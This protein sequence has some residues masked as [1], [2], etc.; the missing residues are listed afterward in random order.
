[1]KPCTRCKK[2]HN[3]KGCYCSVCKAAMDK[4]WRLANPKAQK[5]IDDRHNKK[6]AAYRKSYYKKYWEDRR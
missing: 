4:A 3:K 2:P 5:A 1:M 6:N